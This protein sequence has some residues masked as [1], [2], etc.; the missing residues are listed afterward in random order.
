MISK[1]SRFLVFEVSWHCQINFLW[2]FLSFTYCD[3]Y[4]NFQILSHPSLSENYYLVIVNNQVIWCLSQVINILLHFGMH[5]QSSDSICNLSLY[6]HLILALELLFGISI[7][8]T[9]FIELI[10]KKS[11]FQRFRNIYEGFIVF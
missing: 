5:T 2:L 11:S 3:E 8:K 9:N 4:I 7:I 1:V 6:L 10:I